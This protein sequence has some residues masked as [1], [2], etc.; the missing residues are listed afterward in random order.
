MPARK[1]DTSP[2][3]MSRLSRKCGRLDVSRP[4]LP[5]TGIALPFYK[6]FHFIPASDDLWE[7]WVVWWNKNWQGN[8]KYVHHK[9]HMNWPGIEPDFPHSVKTTTLTLTQIIQ[10][11]PQKMYTDFSVWDFCLNNLLI[12]RISSVRRT[13]SKLNQRYTNKFFKQKYRTLKCV[14]IHVFGPLGT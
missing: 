5:V 8:P 6:R 11:G 12:C 4:Y 14:Y 13:F 1:A 10:R 3:S 7:K 2:P 9:S